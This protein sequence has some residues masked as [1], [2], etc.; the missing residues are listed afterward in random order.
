[1]DMNQEIILRCES[2]DMGKNGNWLGYD[3]NS[4]CLRV[5]QSLIF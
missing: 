1:M 2:L 3:V 5:S 4:L